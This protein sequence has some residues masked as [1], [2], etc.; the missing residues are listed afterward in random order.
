MPYAKEQTLSKAPIEGGIPITDE[1]YKQA[2]QDKLAGLTVVSVGKE[3][4]TFDSPRRAVYSTTDGSKK[5]VAAWDETP[6]GFTDTERPDRFHKWDDK[7]WVKDEEA[8]LAEWRKTAS[9]TA[10]QGMEQLIV[11]GLDEHVENIIDAI[12]DPVNQ[13]LARNWFSKAS[14]WERD[15]AQLNQIAKALKL[16][17]ER[18]DNLFRDAKVR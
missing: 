15:N 18:M 17:D 7:S 4:K 8:E 6:T 1:Q 5:E 2:V 3:L 13:K 11:E 16:T 14:V 12:E 9:V 10:R